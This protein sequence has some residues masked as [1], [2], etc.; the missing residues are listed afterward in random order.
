MYVSSN[1]EYVG[2]NYLIISSRNKAKKDQV[3]FII[4]GSVTTDMAGTLSEIIIKLFS[5]VA[6]NMHETCPEVLSR[7]LEVS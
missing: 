3:W 7:C 2:L 6:E 4:A 5:F 1:N